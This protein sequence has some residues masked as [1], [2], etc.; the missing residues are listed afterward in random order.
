MDRI[1]VIFT[2]GYNYFMYEQLG[3]Q[4]V[5]NKAHEKKNPAIQFRELAVQDSESEEKHMAYLLVSTLLCLT[6]SA[7]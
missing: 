4:F 3:M 1:P 6:V 2:A 5:S 7:G